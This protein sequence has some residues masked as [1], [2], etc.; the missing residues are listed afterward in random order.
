VVTQEKF[1]VYVV[2]DDESIR[3]ALKRLL[4]SA[5]YPAVTFVSAEDFMDYAPKEGK[6]CLVLDIRLPKMTGLDLE[7]KL[8]SSG[9]K[10]PVIFMTGHENP[11]WEERAKKAGAVAY[12]KKPFGDRALL[13]AI[14]VAS[15]EGS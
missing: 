4:S 3:R 11:Q 13:D 10:W 7:E 1:T 12:L 14:R 9:A 2:D 6:G 15:G 8:A 5:N